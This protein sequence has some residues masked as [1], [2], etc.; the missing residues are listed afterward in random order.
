MADYFLPNKKDIIYDIY[1]TI[2]L[3]KNFFEINS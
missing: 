3:K 1:F 2:I